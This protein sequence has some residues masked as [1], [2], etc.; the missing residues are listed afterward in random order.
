MI[1][2]TQEWTVEATRIADVRTDAQQVLAAWRARG[3]FVDFWFR[4]T[5]ARLAP[6]DQVR[7][8]VSFD[9]EAGLLS[10]DA[11]VRDKRVYGADDF[12]G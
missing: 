7:V 2:R 9:E 8:V 3:G 6:D 1:M 4:T 5:T 11:W 12:L 10:F